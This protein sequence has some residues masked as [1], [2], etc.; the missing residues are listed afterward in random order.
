MT[1]KLNNAAGFS[2]SEVAQ[3]ASVYA[4]MQL[5][6]AAMGGHIATMLEGM[7]KQNEMLKVIVHNFENG[8]C[9]RIVDGV[10]IE[11]KKLSTE[12]GSA[13]AQGVGIGTKSFY[14]R[15]TATVGVII[16][17]ISTILGFIFNSSLNKLDDLYNQQRAQLE[18]RQL[19]I[20]NMMKDRNASQK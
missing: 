8:M 6:Y 16:A 7:A 20:E 5:E 14:T 4:K 2:G 17:L 12:I 11:N 15:F 18:Q 13:M 10:A 1:D 3:L 9:R 19:Q